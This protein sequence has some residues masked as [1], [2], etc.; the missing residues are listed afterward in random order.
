MVEVRC[1]YDPDSRGGD[2]R[3]R[4]VRGT[5]H[6]VSS[7]HSIPAEVRLYDHLFSAPRPDHAQD[8]KTVLN[9]RSLEVARGARLEPMLAGADRGSRFQFERHGYFCV[10]SRDST[11]ARL[12]F[13]R[14]VGL[15][16]T[17]AKIEKGS[18]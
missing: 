8:W 5:I 18:S 9:P 17:W 11:P 2:S 16:D 4:R 3:G 14:A 7:S 10:D 13:N 1:T 12:V 15:R 6:W